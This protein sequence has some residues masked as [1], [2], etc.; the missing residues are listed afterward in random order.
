[1]CKGRFIIYNPK[2]WIRA[3]LA[4]LLL[5]LLF[6]RLRCDYNYVNQLLFTRCCLLN[7]DSVHPQSPCHLLPQLHLFLRGPSKQQR[8]SFCSF[9]WHVLHLTSPRYYSVNCLARCS[10][11]RFSSPQSCSIRISSFRNHHELE[12][13]IATTTTTTNGWQV[14]NTERWQ[15]LIVPTSYKKKNPSA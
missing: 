2:D 10:T 15:Q 5:L 7:N 6:F 12:L 8:W 3:S 11:S 14:H 9:H 1:M 4:Q 13:N